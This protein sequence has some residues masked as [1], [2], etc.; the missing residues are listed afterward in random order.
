MKI[1]SSV[2][3]ASVRGWFHRLGV[4]A[5]GAACAAGGPAAR[6]GI[7]A[8]MPWTT[9]EAEDMRVAGT[10]LGPEY[11]PHRVE[12]ESSGQRCVQL[13]R[14]GEHVEF[15]ATAK[16]DSLVI[17]FNLPDAAA[18]GGRTSLLN[19]FV[20]GRLVRSLP[21]SSRNAWLYGT[22]PFANDPGQGKP[23]NF[24]DELR[25]KGLRIEPGDRIRLEKAAD[26]GSACIIDLVD[27]E[28]VPAPV[29]R[30][31]HSLSVLDF[32]ANGRG[33][34]D[35]TAALRQCL[36]EAGRQ[37]RIV[38][39]PA[40][41]Y[42]ITGDIVVPAAVTIQGAGMWHTTFE[43]DPELYGQPD[44]RV[45]FRLVGDGA[46]VAD[47]AIAGQLN[48]RNDSEPNDGVVVTGAKDASVARLWVEHTKAGVWVYNGTRLVVEGCRFRN[49]LA[50]GVNFCVGTSHSVV[51]QC[52][53]RGTGDDCYA[54]W[55][56]AA[57]QG[58]EEQTVTPGHNVIRRS[59][60]QLTFLANGASLY[61][62]ANNRIEECLFTD[63]ATGCGILI[64]TTFLTADEQR[65]VDNN[66]SGTT[67][68]R[69]CR[70]VRCGGY[71]H[72]WTWRGAFQVCMD[73]R[74][75]AGLQVSRVE[76][77]D[78]ISDGITVVG[79]GRA[80]GEGTLSDA[81]FK[82]VRV[83][84]VGLGVPGRHGLLIREDAAGGLQLVRSPLAGV[85]NES[86]SFAIGG[87]PE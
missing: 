55:P 46:R 31:A 45:R 28:L 64:S 41:D 6:A 73:R 63:I 33:E 71:D 54:V 17:R 34:A 85:R 44:R 12:T 35:D 70:L 27:L 75:I 56:A 82:D 11:G 62:G 13:A 39:V 36:A 20:N 38:W 80:K 53:A 42:R 26:D 79:P 25:L 77:R 15:S 30:P 7:G 32:G 52:T 78:S 69:D 51:E 74:R 18:G 68:V 9:V 21:L 4:L 19:L 24:Y 22:Y 57:D 8:E 2:R 66:F 59:T 84:G 60:G 65:K 61:G 81:V 1:S 58:H 14:A 83:A 5:L 29:A 47:F 10:V 49:L 76:I 3:A 72:T 86:N 37:G 40:G 48:Y 50:D 87:L 16:F 67:E 23:R 43:G